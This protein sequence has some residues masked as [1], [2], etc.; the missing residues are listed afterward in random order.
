MIL[1]AVGANLERVAGAGA[2]QS[3]DEAVEALARLPGLR[4]AARSR[5]WRSA[6]VPASTQPDFCNGVVRLEAAA[7]RAEPE[8]AL[9]LGML[10]G[11]E[12]AFGRVR[13]VPNAARTLDLDLLAMGAGGGA[14]RDEPDPVLP[15]PRAT[16]RA[17]V[18]L[19]LREVA[20]DWVD[21]RSGL[22]V[23]ALVARLPAVA[24][25]PAAISPLD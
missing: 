11:I 18:L 3:C 8:P 17:F 21:P 25:G 6:P 22:G 16:G 10:H 7:G 15:H 2:Y 23:A 19:P 4:V 12:A 14:R 13:G 5:W 24:V 20:P 1:V 9:L